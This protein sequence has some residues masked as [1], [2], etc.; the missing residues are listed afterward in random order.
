MSKRGGNIKQSRWTTLLIVRAKKQESAAKR[1]KA[2]RGKNSRC[3]VERQHAP[4]IAPRLPRAAGLEADSLPPEPLFP[5]TKFKFGTGDIQWKRPQEDQP[6]GQGQEQTDCDTGPYADKESPSRAASS[7][8][9]TIFAGSAR[10]S[11][12]SS[13]VQGKAGGQGQAEEGTAA[14]SIPILFG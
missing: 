6:Q 2:E 7:D 4:T 1:G 9:H 5:V 3:A 10:T 14:T 11:N 8:N 13:Q 12:R